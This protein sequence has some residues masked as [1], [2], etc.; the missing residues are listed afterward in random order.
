MIEIPIKTFEPFT[1]NDVVD[2]FEDVYGDY[3]SHNGGY[4]FSVELGEAFEPEVDLES[5]RKICV[6]FIRDFTSTF[7]GY[8]VNFGK[9]SNPTIKIDTTSVSLYA[10]KEGNDELLHQNQKS[11]CA[12]PIIA[13]SSDN[14]IINIIGFR[15]PVE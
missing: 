9:N 2:W 4:K 8:C 13:C 1:P 14:Q 7:C 11:L 5:W 10:N 6:K 15:I 3:A 12:Y